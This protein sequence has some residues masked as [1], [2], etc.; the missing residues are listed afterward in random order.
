MEIKNS[1]TI[2]HI[3]VLSERLFL[4]RHFREVEAA[5]SSPVIPMLIKPVDTGILF[6]GFFSL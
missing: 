2:V 1:K 5:G 4:C 6:T 3:R